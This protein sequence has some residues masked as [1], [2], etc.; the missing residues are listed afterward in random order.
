MPE[1]G[2]LAEITRRLQHGLRIAVVTI[3]AVILIL[4]LSF[5]RNL[6]RYHP[7]WPQIIAY[8]VL[9][10][11]VVTEA[12]L[13]ARRRSWSR[14]R[15]P[16]LAVVLAAD[17]LARAFLASGA[18]VTS[19][20]W[21]FGALGWMGVIL[22]LDR[23]LG[24]LAAF[25]GMHEAVTLAAILLPGAGTR[26]VLL[27][28][29]AG[30][31]GTIGYPLASGIA[32]VALRGVA[33]A[34]A[35]AAYETEER[36]T[37]EESLRRIHRNR[38]ARLAALDESA[39]RLL[40]GLAN[41]TLDP[42]DQQVRQE[43]LIEAARMRRLFA[44]AD[45]AAEPL[46]HLLEQASDVATRRGVKVDLLTVG[47]WPDPP[48]EIRRSL[49]DAVLPAITAAWSEARI[50]VICIGGVL[51]VSVRADCSIMGSFPATHPAVQVTA[52]SDDDTTWVEAQW[53]T[54]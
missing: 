14:W 35:R 25:L 10:A 38:Q 3:A 5:A 22:L 41:G 52:T 7:L 29:A 47:S 39:G 45:T 26:D 1:Q 12:I 23:P 46:K 9:S 42:A 15:W 36:R 53:A 30:S 19:A 6:D 4:P 27:N 44:E 31:L 13:A 43:C 28:F 50:V 32:A 20:D 21:I 49:T 37:A 54:G 16:A 8:A 24:Y 51:S 48:S 2:H 40:Q 11:I 33:Q 34:A 17:V 18:A